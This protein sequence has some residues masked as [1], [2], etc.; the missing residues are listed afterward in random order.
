MQTIMNNLNNQRAAST[1]TESPKPK[2]RRS[3]EQGSDARGYWGRRGRRNLTAG[4]NGIETCFSTR[5]NLTAVRKTYKHILA[6]AKI[7]S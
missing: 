2:Q 1:Q 4:K 3:M 5:K 7:N 6:C